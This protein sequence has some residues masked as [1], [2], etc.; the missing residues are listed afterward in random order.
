MGFLPTYSLSVETSDN[1]HVTIQLPFALDFEISRKWLGSANTALLKIYNLAEATRN[2]LYKDRYQTTVFR[3]VQFRAGYPDYPLPLLFN[4]N[5][6]QCYSYRRGRDFVT[7]IWGYDGGFAMVNGFSSQTFPKGGTAAQVLQ[8][9]ITDLPNLYGTAIIGSF[10]QLNTRAEV[11]LGNT[12]N[13]IGDKSGN[14]AVIDNG[15]VKILNDSEVIAGEIPS[16]T[17]SSGL[18]GSPTRADSMIEA[19]LMFEP[20]LT[21]GQSVAL[22]STTNAIF[23]RPYKVMGIQHRGLIAID[24]DGDRIT[25]V[26]LGFGSQALSM[27]EGEPF[28]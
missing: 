11:L 17:S 13:L 12:W 2:R 15:Q 3:S 23:N 6:M 22:E 16:I 21:L 28:Q 5:V 24:T 10:D 9:L 19:E 14:Q 4:G 25:T 26:S 27:V 20:R 7:E 8:A 1:E 18:L